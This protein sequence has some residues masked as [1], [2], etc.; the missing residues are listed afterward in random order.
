MYTLNNSDT[1]V[2]FSLNRGLYFQNETMVNTYTQLCLLCAILLQTLSG[3]LQA[4]AIDYLQKSDEFNDTCFTN[5]DF[6]YDIITYEGGI[7]LTPLH[8]RYTKF[9]NYVYHRIPVCEVAPTGEKIAEGQNW[10]LEYTDGINTTVLMNI[11]PNTYQPIHPERGFPPEITNGSISGI[12]RRGIIGWI[13]PAHLQDQSGNCLFMS[14]NRTPAFCTFNA[15]P[16]LPFYKMAVNS[17][18]WTIVQEDSLVNNQEKTSTVVLRPNTEKVKAI[19]GSSLELTFDKKVNNLIRKV[20]TLERVSVD[21][22]ILECAS[23]NT[24][25]EF[26]N[27]G[28]HRY[29]PKES[30]LEITEK[31]KKSKVRKVVIKNLSVDGDVKAKCIEFKIP[32]NL[33]LYKPIYNDSA[34]IYRQSPCTFRYVIMGKDNIPL[35]ELG[36]DEYRDFISSKHNE[37]EKELSE[38]RIKKA[39]ASVLLWRV[40]S[41]MTGL[42]LIIYCIYKKKRQHEDR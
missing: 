29:F 27:L 39:P 17:E 21:D 40:I 15:S 14:I 32:E 20:R 2:R 6:E 30:L 11:D 5:V 1:F 18:Y 7:S 3:V 10:S 13:Y 8:G 34:V 22:Q 25:L 41:A 24:V 31:G 33:V 4:Q 19:E 38:T 42:A 9:G 26:Y 28:H 12:D 35:M 16:L 36:P 37:Y 23:E